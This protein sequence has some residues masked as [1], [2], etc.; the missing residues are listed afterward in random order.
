M[1]KKRGIATYLSWASKILAGLFCIYAALFLPER[2]GTDI[3]LISGG[4]MGP[5]LP[6]DISKIR[7]A[8]K[9]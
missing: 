2:N 7:Q 9:E 6:I 3:I 8:G 5:F 1:K 4:I